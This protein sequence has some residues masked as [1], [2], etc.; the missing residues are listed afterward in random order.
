[1][2]YCFVAFFFQAEDGIRDDLVTGVQTCAL[3]ILEVAD[4]RHIEC[5]WRYGDHPRPLRAE[6]CHVA[7]RRSLHH[8]TAR[9]GLRLQTA[10]AGNCHPDALRDV[11]AVDGNAWR[12][13]ETGAR[14]ESVGTE[15]GADDFVNANYFVNAN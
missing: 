8:V 13:A 7:H 5:V 12:V 14:G 10:A 1:M 6:D 3:P 11:S 15:T 4:D 9:G 2:Y